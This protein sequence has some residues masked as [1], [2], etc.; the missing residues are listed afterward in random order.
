MLRGAWRNINNSAQHT[1]N[2]SYAN[3]ARRQGSS[4]HTPT[5]GVSSFATSNLPKV[6]LS[7]HGYPR[8]YNAGSE[9][10]TQTIALG[11]KRRGVDVSV[12]AREEDPFKPDY[13]ITR[14]HDPILPSIPVHIVN[15]ARSNARYQNDEIDAAF[16]K[17]LREESPD[18]V[19][20]GHLNH[21]SV[22]MVKKAKEHNVK[23]VFT[24]HDFWMMCPRGQF[25]QIGLDAGEPWKACSGQDNHKCATVCMNRFHTGVTTESSKQKDEA[26]WTEWVQKRM[27]EVRKACS[28]V[29]LFIAPSEHLRKRFIEEYNI[30]ADKIIYI[31]YG[32][33]LS[34]LFPPNKLPKQKQDGY[35]FGYIGRHHPSKGIDLLI[36]AFARVEGRA[37]LIVWGRPDGQLSNSLKRLAQEKIGTAQEK[38]VEWR[39]E[40]KN[41]EIVKD[42]FEHCDCIVVPS[43]WDENSPLVIHE[44]QQVRVPVITSEHGGMSEFVKDKINGLTFEHRSEVSLTKCLQTAMDNPLM[45]ALLGKRGYIKSETGDIP[46][47]E[48]HTEELLAVYNALLDAPTPRTS[49]AHFSQPNKT[50]PY[51]TQK[52]YF[53]TKASPT[54]SH[55]STTP[56]PSVHPVSPPSLSPVLTALPVPPFAPP[57]LRHDPAPWRI[58]FDTNPDDCNLRCIMCEEHSIY[59]KS[60]EERKTAGK[61]SRRM[62]INV[63]RKVVEECAPNGLKEISPSTMGEPLMYKHF[64]EIIEICKANHVKMNL[65]TNGTFIG[66]GV[67][68]WGNMILPVA[69]DIKI[70]WNG[71]SREI[72]EKVM[73]GSRFDKQLANLKEFLKI[74]DHIAATQGNRATV[75]LQLTYMEVN[76][77]EIPEVVKLAISLG[78][79]RVK[80][81]HLWAHFKEIKMQNMRRS[82]EAILKWNE[83]VAECQRIARET[84]LP[85]GKKIVLENIFAL[86]LQ[87]TTEIHP[88][89][90]CPFLGKEAWVNH[91][92]RF[93]PCCA[94][95]QERKQLGAFGN[96]KDEGLLKLWNAQEYK[97]LVES[98]FTRDLCKK[99]NMRKKPTLKQ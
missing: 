55:N 93:D 99:C 51:S 27:E 24:L 88:E 80:G 23:V 63:I 73:I 90:T 6:L 26:Y 97:N 50:T 78:V 92:G 96:V 79:D 43:I 44:A 83:I 94:P 74:R 31:D 42:V 45:M 1:R 11:L 20:M 39:S 82:E 64:P 21:L 59:S 5:R 8:R 35:I 22:G 48:Q 28:M 56:P 18:V 77:K 68:E 70:S 32:F 12:F 95:D 91:E 57:P 62:D 41:E 13:T 52:S 7:I 85:N 81:H 3:P 86:D 4:S 36:K 49:A 69:S 19:H 72:A 40:Y 14:E 33:D 9:V 54:P 29:D 89:A 71:A 10:Y 60:Q 53:H 47:S 84:L 15:H 25:L 46:S 65:T 16:A 34:R 38:V 76:L 61:K 17:V 58:T 67:H 66:R 87:A 37:K 30:P 75:T 98:Y 2:A